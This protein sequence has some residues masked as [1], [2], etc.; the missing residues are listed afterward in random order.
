MS[1]V[2]QSSQF[3]YFICILDEDISDCWPIFRHNFDPYFPLTNVKKSNYVS[4]SERTIKNIPLLNIKFIP[5]EAEL[6]TQKSI[7]NINER[8]FM[9]IFI[10][11]C[12]VIRFLIY[13]YILI[14]FR[15]L[16]S[17]GSNSVPK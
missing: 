11:F 16:T 14:I 3:I 15:I 5:F 4:Q 17:T 12:E 8:P 7:L 10:G 9:H 6:L 13:I 2:F 1:L